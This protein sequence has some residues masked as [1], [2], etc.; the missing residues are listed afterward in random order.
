[1][2]QYA[3]GEILLL[4]FPF[5]DEEAGKRRPALLLIDVGDD[6][7]VVARIT[8][9]ATRT[10]FDIEIKKWQQAGLKAASFIR[11]HKLATLEKEL[12]DRKL[13]KL[14]PDDWKA[15]QSKL[16]ELWESIVI[17]DAK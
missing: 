3:P 4:K 17:E 10:R 5:T 9:H 15:V 2:E 12:I 11:L 6:D 13:G 14:T 8:T 7:V 1:M 16:K